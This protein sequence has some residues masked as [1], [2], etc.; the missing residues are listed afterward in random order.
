MSS[1]CS[2][3][4]TWLWL[5][6]MAVILPLVGL[7]ISGCADESARP[8]LGPAP[9]IEAQASPVMSAPR[10]VGAGV[11][12][13]PSSLSGQFGV[14]EVVVVNDGVETAWPVLVASTVEQRRQG[15]MGVTD[16]GEFV[17]MIFVFDADTEAAFWM[18]DTPLAL[19][20][21]FVDSAGAVVAIQ[22][23]EPCQASEDCPR[24]A[25]GG[26]YRMALEVPVGRFATLEVD[27]SS[28]IR[29]R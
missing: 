24:Y 28:V 16:L 19:S 6:W 14:G 22:A 8:I 5:G 11:G 3:R 13:G 9:G 23:M 7:G 27:S 2:L 20:I 26:R 25:A 10:S 21:A 17:G 12:T 15:L 18:K 29:L 1:A 4:A